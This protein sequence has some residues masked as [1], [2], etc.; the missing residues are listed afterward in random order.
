MTVFQ[1][2]FLGVVQGLTEFLPVSSSGHLVF[3]QSLFGLEKPQVAFDVMLHLGT[4]LAVVVYF[5]VDISQILLGTWAWVKG[6]SEGEEK[7]K[8]LLWIVVA[9]VPTGLMG[10]IFKDWFES[11][12]SRPKTVGLMLLVTGLLLWLTRTVRREEKRTGE[13]GVSDALFIGIAQGVAIIPGISRSGVTISTGLFLGL[14]RELAGKF[15]FLLS[16]P[17]ILGATLLE[18]REIDT[19]SGIGVAFI[20]SAVAFFVGLFSL[21]L[22]MRIVRTGRLFHFSYYCWAIGIVM[23]LLAR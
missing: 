21:K 4:L 3:F 19:S 23:V 14:N 22:L 18:F 2:I 6:R 13:M 15:S 16:I 12:F 17:A 20:G 8:L 11:L 9:S 7:V 1:A 5:R 10:I